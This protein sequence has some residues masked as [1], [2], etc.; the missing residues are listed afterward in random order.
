VLVVL[1]PG[2]GDMKLQRL[3]QGFVQKNDRPMKKKLWTY[4]FYFGKLKMSNTWRYALFLLP[5]LFWELPNHKICQLEFGK[6]LEM[7]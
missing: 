4:F 1:S 6:L 5:I 7:L 3:E 2:A